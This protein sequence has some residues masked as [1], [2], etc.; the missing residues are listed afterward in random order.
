MKFKSLSQQIN[1]EYLIII[2]L[3][4]LFLPSTQRIFIYNISYKINNKL[5]K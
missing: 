3:F 4:D 5:I 1:A 2:T